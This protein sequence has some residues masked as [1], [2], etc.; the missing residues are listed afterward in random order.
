MNK[1]TG[2]RNPPTVNGR[3][4]DG[5]RIGWYAEDVAVQ[6]GGGGLAEDEIDGAGH[7]ALPVELQLREDHDRSLVTLDAAP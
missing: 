5:L 1:A 2:P 4:T 3:T 7:V 6:R